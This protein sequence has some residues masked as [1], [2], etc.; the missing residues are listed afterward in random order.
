VR[1]LHVYAVQNIV[2]W[3]LLA[4]LL[5]RWF[6]PVAWSNWFRWAAVLFSFGLCFS[7]RASLVDG[8]SL[9]LVASGVAL[10]EAGWPWL[11]A[12]L[13]GIAGLGKE[14]NI[15]A[16]AALAT[17]GAGRAGAGGASQ[18]PEGRPSPPSRLGVALRCLLVAA[19]LAVWI[20]V[21][22]RW[23]G[24][25]GGAGQRNF[26][27]P[28]AGYAGK[29]LETARDFAA[30]GIT[31]VSRG[32]LLA[33][34]ALT[35]QWLFL[36]LRPRPA[37]PW[38]RVGAAFAALMALMGSAVWEGFPGAASRVLLPM[39]LAFNILVPR[40]RAWWP[41]LLIGN[42]SLL[43]SPDAMNLPGRES[44]RVAG[45]RE[46]RIVASNGRIVEA[47]FDDQWY[48]QEQ[49]LLEYWRWSRGSATV[50][51][52]NP[53][54]FAVTADISF[55]LRA[56]DG[57]IADVRQGN[58]V[59]WLGML[60]PKRLRRIVIR[61]IRLEPGDTVW[62]LETDQPAVRPRPDDPRTVAFSLRDLLITLRPAPP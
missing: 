25:S 36:V 56:A 18:P 21:V 24:E 33:L 17:V 34:T 7:V 32:E 61:G 31:F 35:A 60:E 20:A 53:H 45:P 10:L 54:P 2:C 9:F 58:H 37:E 15:L 30:N 12:A 42:L 49:S 5:L 55:G 6:P 62:R 22:D 47:L 44:Y 13:L 50:T 26:G 16:G 14:T 40:A 39:T 3:F 48:P 8:P 51:L 52:R 11:S 23:L 38:W 46:L 59:Y 4:A 57:R 27:W 41:V 29:W 1:A 28:F 43:V 19:P